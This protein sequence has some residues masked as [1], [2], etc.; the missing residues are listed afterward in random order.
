M[1][2]GLRT[3]YTGYYTVLLEELSLFEP[4]TDMQK[5]VVIKCCEMEFPQVYIML[6]KEGDK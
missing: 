5:Q 3:D 6:N 2:D 4:L 1:I